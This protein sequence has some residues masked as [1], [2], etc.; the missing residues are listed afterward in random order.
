MYPQL[1][2][3]LILAIVGILAG[4]VVNVLADDLPLSRAPRVPRFPDG[5]VRPLL[6]WL[7]IT[8]FL[9]N[10]R[11]SRRAGT[12]QPFLERSD[13]PQNAKASALGWRHPLTELITAAL[14]LVLYVGANP[15]AGEVAVSDWMWIAY[16]AL[17]VLIGI[18]DIEHRRIPIPLLMPLAGL[19]LFDAAFM[20]E[21]SP[22][23]ASAL[24]R[25]FVRFSDL[26][27]DIRRR[28]SVRR[29]LETVR[30]TADGCKCNRI[31]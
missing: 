6:A 7:G 1:L 2:E 15:Q 13:H 5:S 29:R 18:V 26:L 16:A 28:I 27:S 3:M 20:R 8:A 30:E 23:L 4:G 31:W 19:A 24:V 10:L 22:N 12:K 11:R 21:T 25:R 14:V 9:L 17:Y